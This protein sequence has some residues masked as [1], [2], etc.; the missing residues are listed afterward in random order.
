M[1]KQFYTVLVLVSASVF[2]AGFSPL[3][4]QTP[5]LQ[6]VDTHTK[7]G[8]ACT[9]CH[10]GGTPSNKV[11]MSVCT[12][13]HGNYAKIALKTQDFAPNPHE[14]H[15]GEVECTVCHHAHKPSEDGCRS[16]HDFGYKVP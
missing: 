15:L 3:L 6:L 10:P 8:I 13:C 16:C 4:S 2:F 9:S 7:A 12:E 5:S 11:P 1:T 14:S